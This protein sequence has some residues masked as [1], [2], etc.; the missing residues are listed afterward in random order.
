VC[1]HCGESTEIAL[2]PGGGA[3]QTYE[4]DCEVCCRTWV[5]RVHYASDGHADVSVEAAD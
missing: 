2:D 3:R 4:E 1:P 5:V